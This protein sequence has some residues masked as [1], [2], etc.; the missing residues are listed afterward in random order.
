M[1]PELF[2]GVDD[3]LRPRTVVSWYCLQMPRQQNTPDALNRYYL[4]IA[5]TKIDG[6]LAVYAGGRLVYRSDGNLLWN[7]S[8]HPLWLAL[9]KAHGSGPPDSLMLRIERLRA[10]GGAVSSIWLGRQ[11]EIGWRY[12]MRDMLQIQLPLMTSAAFLAVGVF[13]LFVWIRQKS[14]SRKPDSLYLLFF[15][16]SLAA[17][18]RSLHFYVGQFELPLPD[19]WLGWLTVSSL[20]W[21]IATSHFLLV[22]LHRRP[23]PWLSRIV[24]GITALVSL[25]TLPVLSA[26]LPGASELSRII[27]LV[28]LGMGFGVAFS[29][30]SNARQA[31]SGEALL[32]A[33]WGVVGMLLG[34][35]DWLLQNNRSAWKAAI[36]ASMSAPACF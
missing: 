7:G 15:A 27:S 17:F 3:P 34:V 9:D 5:R 16:M 23:Q 29:G 10:T 24:I 30:L 36:S 2:P 4:Y 33:S 32:L 35:H 13:A 19:Q 12:R 25:I 11:D 1:P 20:F 14:A 31:G 28:L 26:V 6:Q 22:R 21:L 18:F 8:N